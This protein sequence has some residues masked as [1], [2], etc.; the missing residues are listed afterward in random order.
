MT[1]FRLRRARA[2]A[3]ALAI[4]VATAPN[5]FAQARP[6]ALPPIRHVFV[7]V[8]ENQGFDSTFRLA[9]RAP[10]LADTLTK[11]GAFLRQYHGIG[12]FS[13][14]NYVAMISGIAPTRETQIDCPRY[15]DF[16][17]TGVARD[18]QPIGTGCI[19]PSHVSTIANQ[20]DAKGLTWRAFMEDMGSDPARESSRCGH[21]AIGAIDSTQ[22]AT[23]ADQYATK[24]NPFMY[25]HAVIDSSSCQ[26]NVVGLSGLAGALRSVAET[27]NFSFISPSLCHDGHDHPCVTGEP[28]GLDAANTFLEHWVPIITSSPAFRADGLLIIVFDEALSFEAV[29]C[30]HELSGPNVLAAGV[31]GPGG[32][33]TGA[34]LLSPFIKPKTVSN[35][36]YNHYSLLRTLEDIFGLAHLGYAGQKGLAT[37]GRDVFSTTTVRMRR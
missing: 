6:S 12:H 25:F 26:R 29:A 3:V 28:G 23:L 13:L 1:S 21:P 7:I 20:L 17:E 16:V 14:P 31:N 4:L 37:L 32:G 33:R 11:A 36:P 27:P 22:R 8:L 34:V 24:H 10:Y 5:G 18:G 19:Y 15:I 2:T 30:C 9:T 35:V